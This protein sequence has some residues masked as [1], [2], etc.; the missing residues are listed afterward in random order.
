MIR[1]LWAWLVPTLADQWFMHFS[2]QPVARLLRAERRRLKPLTKALREAHA[3]RTAE[4]AAWPT[5]AWP[6]DAW[7]TDAWFDDASEQLTRRLSQYLADNS[8]DH[9]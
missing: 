9:T 4:P 7:L 8:P 2:R 3:K 6:T 5:D 1:R